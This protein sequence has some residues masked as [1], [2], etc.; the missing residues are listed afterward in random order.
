MGTN[1]DMGGLF[2]PS[3]AVACRVKHSRQW[4]VIAR[5]G[6]ADMLKVYTQNRKPGQAYKLTRDGVK[7]PLLHVKGR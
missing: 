7:T 1:G 5:G 2:P 4:S 3:F 6:F